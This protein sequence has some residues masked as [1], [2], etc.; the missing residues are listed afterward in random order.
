MSSL[1]NGQ[2][3]ISQCASS[4]CSD[5]ADHLIEADVLIVVTECGLCGRGEDG[6]RQPVT[7]FETFWQNNPADGTV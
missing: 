2:A 4:L 3:V 1:I 6:L 5:H 7:F